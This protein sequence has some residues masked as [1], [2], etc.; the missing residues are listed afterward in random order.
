MCQIN[1]QRIEI[2]EI[3][4]HLKIN[5]PPEAQS[6]VELV[7]FLGETCVKALVVFLH[8]PHM[9][10]T[11]NNEAEPKVLD[12]VDD[13]VRKICKRLEQAL[14]TALPSYYVPSLF[15][16]V[17]SMPMTTSGKL[18]RKLLRKMAQLIPSEKLTTYRLVGQSGRAPQGVA[19]TVLAKL[20]AVILNLSDNSVGAEDSFFRLGGDSLGAMRLVTACRKEGVLLTVGSVFAHPTLAAMAASCT[21]LD[22]TAAAEPEEDPL[23][24]QLILE[25][26]RSQLIE[27]ASAEIG[28]F[29]DAIEDIYPCSRLQAGLIAISTKEPGAYVA[30]TIYRLPRDVDI[31][32]FRKSWDTVY[33]SEPILRTRIIHVDGSGFLQVI[34][35]NS[36]QWQALRSVEDIRDADRHVPKSPGSPLATY[37]IVGEGTD[38]QFFVWTAHH[39]IYDGW[40]L[41]ALLCKVESCYYAAQPSVASAAPF[42]RFIRYLSE[43][44][45]AESDSYWKTTCEGITAS[46]FPQLPSPDHVVQASKRLKHRISIMR[47]PGSDITMPTTIRAAWGLLLSIYSSSNDVVWGETTSGREIPVH[48]IENI[49]GP[50]IAT[51]PVRLLL[52][53]QNSIEQYLSEVQKRS[54]AALSFQFAGLQHIRKLSSDTAAACQFQSLLAIVT[55]DGM[56]DP[57]GG[58]WSLQSTGTVGTNFF[59]YSLIFNCTVSK[60]SVDLEVSH[61]DQVLQPWL[62]QRLVDEF[63]HLIH[64]LN[65]SEKQRQTLFELDLL[66]ESD[67]RALISWNL[68]PANIIPKCIHNIIH[69]DQCIPRPSAIAIDAWDIGTMSYRELDERSTRLASKLVSL[70]VQPQSFVPIC[71]D[72]SGWTIIAMLAILKCGAAFVPLDFESPLLRLREIVGDVG[73]QVMVCGRNYESL[74]HSIPCSTLVVERES[75]DRH[76]ERLYTLPYVQSDSPAYVLF[77]SGSTG[78]PKGAII[79]H[80]SWVSSSTAFAPTMGLSELSRVLQFASYT[81]DACLIEIFSTLMV[82]GTVCVP[83]QAARTNDLTGI[84][85]KFG[86]NWATLTPTVV[87]TMQPTQVPGLQAL[88][89]IGEPMS[90]QDLLTWADHLLLGNGYGPTE[91]SAIATVN[92]MTSTT[93]PNNLGKA[94][95]ARGWVVYKDDHDQL[96]PLGAVGELVLEGGGVGAG[97][98]NDAEKTAKAFIEPPK[99]A[100]NANT[101]SE[102]SVSSF[103]K[104]GD[105]VRY[106]EDGTLLVGFRLLNYGTH[107]C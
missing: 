21:L 99:W 100:A 38:C 96:V 105:L 22:P 67:K 30:E 62:V 57:D 23:P 73:A 13:G 58:L 40:S 63:D 50:T 84:I 37:T 19:E 17:S 82:G 88:I 87:R 46:P 94:I 77:T 54:S 51:S 60:D 10:T 1:G 6:A 49:I 41:P 45:E 18:D 15:M 7:A 3:E 69:Q 75:T 55:G 14:A 4:H 70:G 56:K 11:S 85:N 34:V 106:N 8:L 9:P 93:K 98:L 27:I 101:D 64:C 89:L 66:N 20:W 74:C 12:H 39:A 92:I 26:V 36:I 43:I 33:A 91:C 59:N 103:Y 95:T 71:F 53:R 16:P 81:F 2:G 107:S 61:D 86:V 83:D 72:K 80:R 65:A 32:R 29:P 52:D 68:K 5:L 104:T 79:S 42:S 25:D 76:A 35:R 24:F 48:D 47:R 102:K 44:D 28:V 78:K 31:A 90:Q 97:Y